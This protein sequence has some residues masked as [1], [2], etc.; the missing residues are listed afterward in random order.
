MS[1]DMKGNVTRE[2]L[3]LDQRCSIPAAVH[4]NR[5]DHVLY[6]IPS[7]KITTIL[8]V[9]I[10]FLFLISIHFFFSKI[11]MMSHEMF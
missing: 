9:S 7:K 11:H 4:K 10:K 2:I 3:N 1:I 6:S 8:R 5:L